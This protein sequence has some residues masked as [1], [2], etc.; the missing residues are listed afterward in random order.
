AKWRFTGFDLSR[1]WSSSEPGRESSLLGA[2]PATGRAGI[3]RAR[4]RAAAAGAWHIGAAAR[5]AYA[6]RANGECARSVRSAALPGA[7]ARGADAPA[8]PSRA[9]GGAEDGATPRAALS[10]VRAA[11]APRRV[12]TRAD[13]D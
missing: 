3:Q 4:A 9:G 13:G 5:S 1:T 12:P 2:E 8:R 11:G 10:G 6:R 7:D